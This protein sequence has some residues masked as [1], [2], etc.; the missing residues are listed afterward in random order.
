MMDETINYGKTERT[1]SYAHSFWCSMR[2]TRSILSLEVATV[3]CQV[4]NRRQMQRYVR[5]YL[6]SQ[7]TWTWVRMEHGNKHTHTHTTKFELTRSLTLFCYSFVVVFVDIQL[8][9]VFSAQKQKQ[10]TRSETNAGKCNRTFP[11]KKEK[12]RLW[13]WMGMENGK[14]EQTG[15]VQANTKRRKSQ[16]VKC[17]Q[18]VAFARFVVSQ[19]QRRTHYNKR[20]TWWY[21]S[22]TS[23]YTQIRVSMW[24]R[25]YAC[26]SIKFI[27]PLKRSNGMKWKRDKIIYIYIFCR[28]VTTFFFRMMNTK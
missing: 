15:D 3:R 28:S 2:Q 27:C 16:K 26:V 1:H 11:E 24:V 8:K 17:V 7:F 23:E 19:C 12:E 22:N 14:C 20:K 9:C 10:C 4:K 21:I 13:R 25:E 6:Y 18:T 5:I